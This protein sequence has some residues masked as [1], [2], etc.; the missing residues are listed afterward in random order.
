MY[1]SHYIARGGVC[2]R[3]KA[4][5]LIK[6]GLIKVNDKVE[7]NP[8]YEVQ[9][10]DRIVF[11]GKRVYP[12]ESTY[13]VLNKPKGIVTTCADERR[14]QTVLDLIKLKNKKIRLYPVGRLDKDTT[15]LLVLTNDGEMAQKLAHPK[16]RVRKTYMA[17]LDKPL[18]KQDYE[19]LRKGVFLRDG[20]FSPDKLFHPK[21][22][23]RTVG[24]E[25][26]SGKY[27]IIRR[28]FFHL[29]YEVLTLER[30]AYGPL[31]LRDLPQGAWRDIK[32]SELVK[33]LPQK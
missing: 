28:A 8:A 18:A 10:D 25:I 29:G 12:Q 16:Y 5:E 21:T 27:R 22:S 14:R 23:T 7:I 24:L 1:L 4:A 13:I 17:K 33:L 3:R 20:R 31:R 9:Q 26:H 19:K 32:K 6:D 2:A 11:N 15:G 30:V